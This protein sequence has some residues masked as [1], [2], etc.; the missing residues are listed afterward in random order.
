M[1]THRITADIDA[2]AQQVANHLASAAVLTNKMTERVL[3][4]SDEDL[5]AW[6]N[7]QGD[8]TPLFTAHGQLGEAINA[9]A[10]VAT[11]TLNEWGLEPTI[12]TVDV[13]SVP[14]KLAA[15][16]RAIVVD[17]SGWQVVPIPPPAAI[18]PSPLEENEE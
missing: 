12:P 17:S 8:P 14:Q 4:L 11:G 18:T 5:A 7:S 10:H 2:L 3:E 6:L 1:T 15:Q 9:A 16:N 13:R